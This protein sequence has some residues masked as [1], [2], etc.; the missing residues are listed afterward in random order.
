MLLVSIITF[1]QS[2]DID[3]SMSFVQNPSFIVGLDEASSEGNIFQVRVSVSSPESLGELKVLIYE[4]PSNTL[5]GITRL[6]HEEIMSGIYMDG[7]HLVFNFPYLE[8][9]LSYKVILEAQ[10]TKMGY[11]PLVEKTFQ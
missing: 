1:S 10:N 3:F 7:E 2:G 5:L 6:S 11:L 4:F 9:H 8:P